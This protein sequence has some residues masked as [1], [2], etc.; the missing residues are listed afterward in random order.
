MS[1]KFD[2]SLLLN[3][4]R[5]YSL[6]GLLVLLHLGA[7]LFVGIVPLHLFWR[8]G[9]W[10]AL[11][12]SLYHVMTRYGWRRGGR[13]ITTAALDGEGQLAVN[14][15]GNETVV[16]AR[17]HQ[18]LYSPLAERAVA[19]LRRPALA[20]QPDRGPGCGGPGNLQALRAR[21]RLRSPAG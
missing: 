2:S 17:M 9:L 7:A 1:Q 11:A 16:E 4:N 3:I 13:T 18:P 6:T 20:R 19:A 14:F 8:I 15:A 10:A 21:L 5:S 12:L